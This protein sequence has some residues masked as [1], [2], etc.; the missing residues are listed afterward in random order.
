MSCQAVAV[1]AIP[2]MRARPPPLTPPPLPR[3]FVLPA[4]HKAKSE[5]VG[6]RPRRRSPSV[7][8]RFTLAELFDDVDEALT[9]DDEADISPNAREGGFDTTCP[10]TPRQ[11]SLPVIELSPEAPSVPAATASSDIL[12][13]VPSHFEYDTDTDEYKILWK[14]Q[15]TLDHR[16]VAFEGPVYVF[17]KELP[18]GEH[19]DIPVGV[20]AVVTRLVKPLIYPIG[21]PR[22]TP[23]LL[24][25]R[26]LQGPQWL[27]HGRVAF[28]DGLLDGTI[29]RNCTTKPFKSTKLGLCYGDA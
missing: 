10:L 19:D 13:P 15:G 4:E 16:F 1:P 9:S 20:D 23:E 17:C 22:I 24:R 27:K 6:A 21:C 2:Q 12:E 26:E 5:L 28:I 11:L 25:R 8:R 14:W 3:R 7:Y 29:P 18:R